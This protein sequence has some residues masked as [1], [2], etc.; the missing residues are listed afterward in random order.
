MMII[1]KKEDYFFISSKDDAFDV[2]VKNFKEEYAVIEKEN[3]IISISD[4]FSVKENDIFV[5]LEYAQLHKE[6]GTTFVVV[7]NNIDIDNF[8]E[9]FNIVPTLQEAEDV[10]EME[11][12]QRDLGF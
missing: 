5:F 9:D 1:E 4:D 8:P 11:N 7:C 3:I 2:F 12:I 6:N 10:L